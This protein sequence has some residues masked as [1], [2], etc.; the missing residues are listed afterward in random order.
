MAKFEDMDLCW[1][2]RRAAN[3]ILYKMLQCELINSKSVIAICFIPI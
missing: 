3:G 2:K 1:I